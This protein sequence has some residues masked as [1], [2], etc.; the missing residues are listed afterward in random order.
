MAAFGERRRSRVLRVRAYDEIESDVNRREASGG[1]APLKAPA[2]FG[3][4]VPHV[5]PVERIAELRALQA[6]SAVFFGPS[7]HELVAALRAAE[8]DSDASTRALELLDTTPTLTRRW[9][10]SVFGAVTWRRRP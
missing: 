1:G 7:G 3:P 4:W 2:P 9:L 5:D 10:L 6:L 8:T